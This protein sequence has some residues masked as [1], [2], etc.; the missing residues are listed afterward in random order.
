VSARISDY[1]SS[2]CCWITTHHELK[3]IETQGKKKKGFFF[4]FF[5]YLF[6]YFFTFF[7]INPITL[8]GC[9]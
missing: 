4:F 2:S 8:S 9:P 5:F 1:P 6:I 7:S 3:D